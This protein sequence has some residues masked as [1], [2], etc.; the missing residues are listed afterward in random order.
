MSDL[1]PHDLAPTKIYTKAGRI[2][3]PHYLK[4]GVYVGPC[5]NEYR[6]AFLKTY[7]VP[8]T[9]MLWPRNWGMYD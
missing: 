6:E 1:V 7:A 8:G 3:L 5:G 2:Y 4:K 9:M